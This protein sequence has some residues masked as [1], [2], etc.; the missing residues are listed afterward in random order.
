LTI[1]EKVLKDAKKKCIDKEVS[2]SEIVEA[3]LRQKWNKDQ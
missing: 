2:L 1:D 3:L